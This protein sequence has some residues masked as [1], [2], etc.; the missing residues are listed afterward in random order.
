MLRDRAEG[1]EDAGGAE[2]WAGCEE[3]AVS[4]FGGGVAAQPPRPLTL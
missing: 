4:P 2:A 3:L 1:G